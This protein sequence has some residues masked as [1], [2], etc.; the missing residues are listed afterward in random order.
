MPKTRGSALVGGVLYRHGE[1]SIAPLPGSATLYAWWYDASY[2]GGDRRRRSLGTSDSKV[3]VERLNAFIESGFNPEVLKAARRGIVPPGHDKD[4]FIADLMADF[5]ESPEHEGA[6]TGAA[7][8]VFPTIEALCSE[9]RISGLS[10]R[11]QKEIIGH[12]HSR[13]YAT[14]TVIRAMQ[15]IARV[16]NW[17][18]GGD[19]DGVVHSQ[20]RPKIINSPFKVCKVLGVPEPPKRNWHPDPDGMAQV[21]A[22]LADD[23]PMRR[24][25]LTML[26]LACRV[27]AAL[28]ASGAELQGERFNLNPRGR[29]QEDTK[30]RPSLPV[31]WSALAEFETWGDGPWVGLTVQAVGKRLR[32]VGQRLAMPGLCP[33]CF[34]DYASTALRHA[35]IDFPVRHVDKEHREKWMG[36]RKF[37][38]VNDGYGRVRPDFLV[39]PR[40]ATEAFLRD[41]DRRSAG[42]L[43][44]QGPDK[45]PLRD[46]YPRRREESGEIGNRPATATVY[47]VGAPVS[48]NDDDPDPGSSGIQSDLPGPSRG[49]LVVLGAR[50]D[51]EPGSDRIAGAFRQIA[52][53]TEVIEMILSNGGLQAVLDRLA[54]C[55]IRFYER[56]SSG[57]RELFLVAPAEA[58]I[59]ISRVPDLLLLARPRLRWPRRLPGNPKIGRL[60]RLRPPSDDAVPD[61]P[62][63]YLPKRIRKRR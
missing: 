5:L 34:R 3:A 11:V 10:A 37:E 4:P 1:I 19:D 61:T 33:S 45:R 56:E 29:R 6:W 36:H 20:F 47:G 51:L 23:E 49:T 58:L 59:P 38:D 18:A 27:E 41:L 55:G 8:M 28:D 42:A 48:D 63:S 13:G 7:R 9:T 15:F 30:Y 53:K 35:D 62:E 57:D 44:R 40:V 60:A 46:L 2:G 52:D 50:R 21:L 31:P 24:W 43:F 54:E 16:V 25:A 22:L 12:V 17:G 14:A 32:A 39:A 26:A